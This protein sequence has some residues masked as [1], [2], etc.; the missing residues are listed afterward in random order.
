MNNIASSIFRRFPK[1]YD[2]YVYFLSKMFKFSPH[3]RRGYGIKVMDESWDYL[4]VL[5][6]CRFD[7]FKACNKIK[8]KLKKKISRADHTMLWLKKNF[9]IHY[10][11]TIYVS[12]NPFVSDIEF[13]GFQASKYF[14]KVYPVWDCA[15]DKETA[16]VHPREVVATA[17]KARDEFPDKRMI[18]HF[19]QPHAPF[20]GK[21]KISSKELGIDENVPKDETIQKIWQQVRAGKIEIDKLKRAYI[22]NLNLVLAE[23]ESLIEH[24]DGKIVITAD[25]GECFGEWGIFGHPGGTYVK[26]LIEI[27][28]LVIQKDRK[29]TKIRA[30]AK[31]TE[32]SQVSESEVCEKLKAL[33]YLE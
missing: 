7:S 6:A 19:I 1:A 18:I 13:K 10:A 8:G 9:S 32:F 12:A 17:L 21:T 23:V 16:T 24:L 28:W 11:D 29:Q 4:I 2:A 25:H 15:W 14:F 5:D 26:P 31:E 33:G 27:P 30:Q 22:D 20:I 3:A